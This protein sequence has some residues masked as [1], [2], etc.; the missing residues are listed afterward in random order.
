MDFYQVIA[1][2]FR[3]LH[4]MIIIAWLHF[5]LLWTS[6]FAKTAEIPAT[7][8]A[9]IVLCLISALTLQP[10]CTRGTDLRSYFLVSLSGRFCEVDIR[11]MLLR[12]R[13]LF[14]LKSIHCLL[15]HFGA[16]S[17]FTNDARKGRHESPQMS[18]SVLTRT[19]GRRVLKPIEDTTY[20]E[21]AGRL[22]WNFA[23]FSDAFQKGIREVKQI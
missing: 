4:E 12:T 23:V 7:V 22:R 18:S 11:N 8:P 16:Y 3:S 20:K 2:L 9:V 17:H 6:D 10:G 1:N 15:K 14:S 21:I 13:F 5:P 19:A